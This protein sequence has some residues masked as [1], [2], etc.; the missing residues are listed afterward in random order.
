MAK[1]TNRIRQDDNTRSK[2]QAAQLIN[3]LQA[4]VMGEVQ[5]DSTQVSA[6]KALLNKVLPDLQQLEADIQ[7]HR[8]EVSGDPMSPDDWAQTYAGDVTH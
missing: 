1:R 2:I 7:S 8:S 4:C 6:A 5:L 3:R